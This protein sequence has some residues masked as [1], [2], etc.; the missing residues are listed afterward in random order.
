MHLDGISSQQSEIIR[1]YYDEG[2]ITLEAKDIAIRFNVSRVTAKAYL[3]GLVGRGLLKR[4]KPNG[5]THA[6][7]K[8]EEFDNIIKT[9]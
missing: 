3:D 9:L 7:V 4:L 1:M 5:R 6:Y 8:S 2:D